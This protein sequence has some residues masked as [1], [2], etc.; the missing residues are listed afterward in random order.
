MS[1]G[2]PEGIKGQEDFIP[3]RECEQNDNAV[4][5]EE[6]LA[7]NPIRNIM[8]A[9]YGTV[10][11]DGVPCEEDEFFLLPRARIGD[12]FNFLPLTVEELSLIHI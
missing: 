2:A 8:N 7:G 3:F 10:A 9:K 1:I 12:S 11:V 6:D 5:F 4:I